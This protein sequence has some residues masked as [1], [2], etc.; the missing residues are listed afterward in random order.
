MKLC[1]MCCS[2]MFLG[3]TAVPR[4][5]VRQLGAQKKGRSGSL[6]RELGLILN[7]GHVYN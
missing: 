1:G 2:K 7:L 5:M 3:R 6:S 4:G